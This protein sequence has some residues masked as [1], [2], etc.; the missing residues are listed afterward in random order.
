MGRILAL[1]P[2]VFLQDLVLGYEEEFRN[3]AVDKVVMLRG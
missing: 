2:R 3:P 1:I